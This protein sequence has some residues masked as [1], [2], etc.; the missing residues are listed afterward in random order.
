MLEPDDDQPVGGLFERF[1]FS[2]KKEAAPLVPGI[3]NRLISLTQ[4]VET[5]GSV[6]SDIVLVDSWAVAYRDED[7]EVGKGKVYPGPGLEVVR[8]KTQGSESEDW[9]EHSEVNFGEYDFNYT[10][11]TSDIAP[12]I[13]SLSGVT[14]CDRDDPQSICPGPGESKSDKVRVTPKRTCCPKNF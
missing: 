7:Y 10:N 5:G 6:E 4:L 12:V 2:N 3:F 14:I 13:W 1:K 11:S 8:K 9:R